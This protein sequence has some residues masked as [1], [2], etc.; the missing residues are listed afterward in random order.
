MVFCT[1]S[2]W[3]YSW[4]LI[5]YL[6]KGEGKLIAHKLMHWSHVAFL[7]RVSDLMEIYIWTIRLTLLLFQSSYRRQCFSWWPKLY[8]EKLVMVDRSHLSWRCCSVEA[9]R[10]ASLQNDWCLPI[11]EHKHLLYP[12]YFKHLKST[13]FLYEKRI[14]DTNLLQT[15]SC[16]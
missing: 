9:T 10:T 13:I 2:Y 14:P 16:G 6:I 7:L 4:K 1:I 12:G 15:L 11:Q 3:C 8:H 5:F